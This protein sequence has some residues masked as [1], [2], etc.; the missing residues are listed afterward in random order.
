MSFLQ[1]LFGGG[2]NSNNLGLLPDGMME[3][4]AYWQLIRQSRLKTSNPDEMEAWLTERLE[5]CTS[6]EIIGFHL[7]TQQLL[8]QLYTSELWCAAYL[9]NGG[10]SDDAFEYF[11]CWVIAKGKKVYYQALANADNLTAE[12]DSDTEEYEF[13]SFGYVAISAYH[14]QTGKSIYDALPADT[15]P[16]PELILTWEEDNPASMKAVCPRLFKKTQY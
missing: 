7:R 12:F 15:A 10:C 14:N 16:H 6:S 2:N 4:E 5:K 13:E 1:N 3:E 8:H 9:L 11:R